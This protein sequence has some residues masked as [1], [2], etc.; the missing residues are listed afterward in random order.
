VKRA[1][2]TAECRLCQIII[3]LLLTKRPEDAG[4]VQTFHF[5][6]LS[7]DP[8]NTL[9]DIENDLL[10]SSD[11]HVPPNYYALVKDS[12]Y[13]RCLKFKQKLNS[14]IHEKHKAHH[15]EIIEIRHWLKFRV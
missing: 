11:A 14:P 8:W 1:L 10:F 4:S 5:P 15:T 7:Q 9:H 13:L 12:R 6:D 2:Q 3:N